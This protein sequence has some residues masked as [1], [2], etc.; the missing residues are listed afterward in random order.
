[1]TNAGGI[2]YTDPKMAADF[3]KVQIVW[4]REAQAAARRVLADEGIEFTNEA[5]AYQYQ[6]L[7]ED[8]RM[9][10]GEP[11]SARLIENLAEQ[12]AMVRLE[13]SEQYWEAKYD[14]EVNGT[15]ESGIDLE[16]EHQNIAALFGQTYG[17]ASHGF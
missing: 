5:L 1:M 17:D 6:N 2:K 15:D 13:D 10:C 12:M 11:S 7:R 4:H 16:E 3:R 14:R 9:A 8:L